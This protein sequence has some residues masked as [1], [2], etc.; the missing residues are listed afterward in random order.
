M[1]SFLVISNIFYLPYH[2]HH[3]VPRMGRR[4]RRR[5]NPAAFTVNGLPA[6]KRSSSESWSRGASGSARD[7]WVEVRASAAS[8][9]RD[10]NSESPETA[11]PQRAMRLRTLSDEGG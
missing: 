4:R 1:I 3:R 2:V 6:T 10:T 9:P 11:V 7:R 5:G 8:D